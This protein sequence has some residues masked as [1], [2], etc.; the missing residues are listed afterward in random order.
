MKCSNNV[1]TQYI[2]DLPIDSLESLP[3]YFMAERDVLDESTGNTVRSLVRVP[4]SKLFPTVTMDNV[5]ALE[6]NN[7]AITIPTAQVRAVRIVN[8]GS[9]DVMQYADN[10]HAPM[11]LATGKV[12]DL[13]LCQNCGVVNLP[14]H[15]YI[16]G[17]QYY[18]GANGE[19]TTTSGTYKLFIPISSSK[20][21]INLGQ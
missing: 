8:Q 4:S 18:A 9:A 3:E 12:S 11:M 2:G 16:V 14:N 15:Q 17:S 7:T 21:L 20:L 1:E 5:F 6:P 19:P 13:I 10:T